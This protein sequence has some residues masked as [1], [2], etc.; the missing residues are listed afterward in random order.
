V[1][2]A[3]AE[4]AI[5]ENKSSTSTSERESKIARPTRSIHET[6]SGRHSKSATNNEAGV[7]DA[8]DKNKPSTGAVSP[9][10]KRTKIR[11]R[12]RNRKSTLSPEELAALIGADDA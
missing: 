5:R 7:D 6:G 11:G 12:P 3:E 9:M 2:Q 8:L 10:A 4:K 1:A